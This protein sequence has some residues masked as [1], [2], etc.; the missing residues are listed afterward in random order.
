MH[1][2]GLAKDVLRKV[3]EA[4]ALKKISR[5][6]VA[7]I[8]I[9]ETL[10][11]DKEEFFELFGQVSKGTAAEGVK[12]N[13]TIMPLTAFCKSCKHEFKAKEM[14][15]GCPKCSGSDFHIV[16]GKEIMIKDLK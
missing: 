3:L 6:K 12:L 16:S 5:I 11:T 13:V 15:S 9:G 14:G 10:I 2:M 8:N 7:D 1:E 4:A